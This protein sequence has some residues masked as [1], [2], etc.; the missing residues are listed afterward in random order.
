MMKTKSYLWLLVLLV[1]SLYAC[2][3]KQDFNY[4]E[5][6]ELTIKSDTAFSIIQFDVLNINPEIIQSKA[7]GEN[8]TY[9]WKIFPTTPVENMEPKVISTD[10]ALQEAIT[11]PPIKQ[12]YYL[13]YKVTNT[14]TGVS[15]IKLLKVR[16][17]S[18]FKDGWLIC[19]S[20]EGN[21][22]LD[23]IRSD[24][25]R[26]FDNPGASVNQKTFLG[27]ASGS[28]TF[29]SL[30]GSRFDIAFFTDKEAFKF[31]AN[32]FTISGNIKT[33]FTPIRDK[34]TAASSK[35]NTDMYAINDGNLY[36]ASTLDDAL[37]INYSERLTGDYSLFPKVITNALFMTYFYDNKHQ[38]F[39]YLSVG[40]FDLS[41]AFG[42]STDAFDMGNTKLG[43]VAAMDGIK[44][45]GGDD[46]FFVMQDANGERYLYGLSGT[47]PQFSQKILNSPNIGNA[48][49]FAASLT[50][51]QMYYAVA[52]QIYLY[53]MVSNSSKLLY[54]L[55]SGTIVKELQILPT[56][57][58]TLVVA[59]NKGTAGEMYFFKIDNQGNFV[60]QN[61][62]RKLD[63]FGEISSITYRR[64]N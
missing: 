16:V 22:Q 13:E 15:A 4:S 32:D 60:N 61:Y 39:M 29:S 43:M 51:R 35:F 3:K 5:L 28:Y 8:F 24:D 58:K 48:K 25:Y 1:A 44:G 59:A 37:D 62:D 18:V 12:G 30:D 47:T 52:N 50:L 63:G 20:A 10:R 46:Y 41:P 33:T 55:P 11:S 23:F 31:N 34:F 45:F 17:T 14:S 19:N 21:A 7:T 27:N 26:V 57:G 64:L 53:D 38:R 49:T 2:Q 36:A 6:N 56:D 42:S 9:Q 54:T 40:S